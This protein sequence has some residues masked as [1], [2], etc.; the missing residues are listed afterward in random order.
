MYVLSLLVPTLAPAQISVKTSDDR[1]RAPVPG[2]A[3]YARFYHDGY[4]TCLLQTFVL[5]GFCKL[6]FCFCNSRVHALATRVLVRASIG[7]AVTG[8]KVFN[9]YCTV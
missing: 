1:A 8:S 6:H 3:W 4:A 7:T 2:G 5:F 9:V